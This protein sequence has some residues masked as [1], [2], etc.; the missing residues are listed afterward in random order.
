MAV[1]ADDDQDVAVAEDGPGRRE[2]DRAGQ[3]VGLAAHVGDGVLGEF[4]QRLVDPF[5]LQV[6]LALEVGRVEDP[7]P[8][9][10]G[11]AAAVADAPPSIAS[12]LA[13][14]EQLEGVA[15]ARR[16]SGSPRRG[17]A[18]AGPGV[19][20][21]AVARLG[22]VDDRPHPG[23]DQLL[24]G[25]RVDVDVVDDGD[26]AGRQPLDQVLGL[27][28]EPGDAFDRLARGPAPLR[29][30]SSAGKRRRLAVATGSD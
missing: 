10:L 21:A 7:A 8:S 12:A 11:L 17:R 5:A 9:D 6:E 28:A 15:V 3:Q 25:D 27:A 16:R 29:R 13:V 2:L 20:V 14:A 22:G 24:G 1:A 30:E 26:V 23:R 18:S 4:G 19:G